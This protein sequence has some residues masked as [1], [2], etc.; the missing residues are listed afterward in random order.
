MHKVQLALVAVLHSIPAVVQEQLLPAGLHW[1]LL[2]LHHQAYRSKHDPRCDPATYIHNYHTQGMRSPG[3]DTTVPKIVFVASS[4]LCSHV[5]KKNLKIHRQYLTMAFNYNVSV[6]KSRK[7]WLGHVEYMQEIRNTQTSLVG[8]P[9][10][11]L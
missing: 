1:N 4:I 3:Y 10:G 7:R 8:K 9:K 11:K 6:I 2:L 5:L